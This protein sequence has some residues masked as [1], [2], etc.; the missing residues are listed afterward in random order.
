MNT[1]LIATERV[2]G[3]GTFDGLHPGHLD[4]LKQL[5]LL[6]KETIVVIARDEN[7]KKI[8]GKK[9]QFSEKER[10]DAVQK[11]GL[12]DRVLLGHLHDFYECLIT[13]NPTIIG[14]GYDQK[15]DKEAIFERLPHVKIARLKPFQPQRYKSSLLNE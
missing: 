10:A 3:F 11:T 13:Y 2:M 9:P 7:V 4:F 12:A 1:D 5:K 15:A 8:K 6:G 14:L